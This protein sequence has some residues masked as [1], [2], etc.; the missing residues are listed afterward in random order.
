M[1]RPIHVMCV[2]R[3]T[4]AG[5]VGK[6]A[7][8]SQTVLP[9]V[10]TA[11]TVTPQRHVCRAVADV[12]GCHDGTYRSEGARKLKEPGVLLYC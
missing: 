7:L 1:K 4:Q 2:W 10:T 8:Q 5:V 12:V 3:L 9:L 6:H 11:F